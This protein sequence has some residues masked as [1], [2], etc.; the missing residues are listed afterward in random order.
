MA[1]LW[2]WKVGLL[3]WAYLKLAGITG[4]APS[5]SQV[6]TCNSAPFHRSP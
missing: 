3:G 2:V 4:P 1:A 5:A 6:G